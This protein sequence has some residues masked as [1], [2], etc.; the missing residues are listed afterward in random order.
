M[1]IA[2]KGLLITFM[3]IG[4]LAAVGE[5]ENEK[6]RMSMTSICIS[7][8]FAFLASVVWL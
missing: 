3:L 5:Q 6:L 8:I 1:L 4:F 7:S 2:F